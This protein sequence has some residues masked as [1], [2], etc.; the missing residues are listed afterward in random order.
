MRAVDGD[1]SVEPNHSQ[2][3]A[4]VETARLRASR[5]LTKP[6]P[7]R[8]SNH[9]AA[10]LDLAQIRRSWWIHGTELRDLCPSELSR[11]IHHEPTVNLAATTRQV[12]ASAWSGR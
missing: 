7:N 8:A 3:G 2:Q 12:C 1:E 9:G 5:T 4:V 6:S 10:R 11:R